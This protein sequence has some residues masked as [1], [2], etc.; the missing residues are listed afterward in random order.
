MADRKGFEFRRQFYELV[1]IDQAWTSD[2]PLVER[3]TSLTWRDFVDRASE[4]EEQELEIPDVTVM[5]ALIGMAVAHTNPYWSREKT[6]RFM[7]R[8]KLDDVEFIGFEEAEEEEQAD[9]ADARPPE[10]EAPTVISASSSSSPESRSES[11]I[12]SNGSTLDPSG[13]RLSDIS[14]A[15]H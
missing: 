12:P 3:L 15:G 5:H 11:A 7:Q 14:A 2:A 8:V 6:M 4:V 9:A 10:M 13:P 1:T